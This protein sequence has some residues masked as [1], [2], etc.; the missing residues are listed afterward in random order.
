MHQT[1]DTQMNHGAEAIHSV[2]DDRQK[3]TQLHL[4]TLYS[5][6]EA[7]NIGPAEF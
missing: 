3:K 2:G 7:W 1:V 5:D 6:S 4:V